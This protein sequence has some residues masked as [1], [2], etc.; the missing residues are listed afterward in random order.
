MNAL[1]RW[2]KQREISFLHE[3]DPGSSP[4]HY[5]ALAADQN[6]AVLVAVASGRFV[7]V[8]TFQLTSN[9]EPTRYTLKV[10]ISRLSVVESWRRRG[11]GTALVRQVEDYA[12]HQL[13]M[14]RLPPERHPSVALVAYVPEH[15]LPALKFFAK[16]G[17]PSSLFHLQ[18]ARSIDFVRF[19]RFLPAPITPTGTMAI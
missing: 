16:L 11:L 8:L 19:C 4:A 17:Y 6:P 10:A 14:L 15:N 3:I 5:A 1:I 12:S 13:R 9:S 7:G 18:S 2:A